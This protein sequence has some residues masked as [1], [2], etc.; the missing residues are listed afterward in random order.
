MHLL[1]CVC[2]VQ[3]PGR[4]SS[5]STSKGISISLCADLNL[6]ELSSKFSCTHT[7][8]EAIPV[9]VLLQKTQKFIES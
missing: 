4:G 6:A 8:S 9:N 1:F 3:G 2:G 7:K 5:L